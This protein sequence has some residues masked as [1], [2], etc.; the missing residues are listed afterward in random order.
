VRREVESGFWARIFLVNRQSRGKKLGEINLFFLVSGSRIKN[1]TGTYSTRVAPLLSSQKHGGGDTV[2]ANRSIEFT[3]RT[4][5]S[6]CSLSCTQMAE[7][8]PTMKGSATPVSTRQEE[9]V[10]Y[11]LTRTSQA[12]PRR[13]RLQSHEARLYHILPATRPSQQPPLVPRLAALG[14]GGA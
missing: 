3:M 2:Q 12:R 11:H 10:Y 13:V 9:A 7:T 14:I 5:F 8:I 6:I 4:S 1:T